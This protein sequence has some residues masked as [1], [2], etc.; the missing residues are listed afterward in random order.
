MAL[1]IDGVAFE[2]LGARAEE[3]I[4]AHFVERCRR[5]ISGNVAADV[6]LDAVRAYHHGQGVPADEALDTALEF[7]VAGEKRF[8]ARWNRVGVRSVRGKRKVNAVNGG[9]RAQAFENF[10]SDF[11]TTGFQNGIQR[12]KPFLN[13]YVFHAMRLGRYFVI[14]NFGRF[15]V[16]RFSADSAASAA[17]LCERLEE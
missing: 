7:L 11:R 2:L 4:E 8:E 10:R 17:N 13:F 9:M 16:F 3:M 14:H 1:K 12:F 5:S 6:V 15:L